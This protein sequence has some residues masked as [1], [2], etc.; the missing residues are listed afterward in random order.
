M[1]WNI[2]SLGESIDTFQELFCLKIA[3]AYSMYYNY[4]KINEWLW[5]AARD[6]SRPGLLMTRLYYIKAKPEKILKTEQDF[7]KIN[8]WLDYKWLTL[9]TDL[10]LSEYICQHFEK[11]C[12]HS[13]LS[14]KNKILGDLSRLS[15]EMEFPE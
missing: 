1:I 6:H 5:C 12:I 13:R 7:S 4:W 2:S 3:N 8:Q 10:L 11:E 14:N 15:L 9:K